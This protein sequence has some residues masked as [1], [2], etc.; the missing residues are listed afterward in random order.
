DALP[1]CG[2]RIEPGE[3]EAQLLA[4]PAV[5]DAAV[6]AC[7]APGGTALVAWVSLQGDSDATR[8]RAALGETL[9][10]YMVPA[11]IT[12]LAAL[13]LNA[14]GKVD[15]QALPAPVFGSEQPYAAPQGD[16]EQMLARLWQQVLSVEHV[17]RADNFFDLGGDSILSLQI[18]ARCQQAGWQITPRQMFEHQTIA[19][20]ATVAEPVQATHMEEKRAT[21]RDL[22]PDE[23]CDRLALNEAQIEDVYPLSPTQEGMLFHSM[24]EPGMYINQLSIAVQGLDSDR[25]AQAWRTM[26][27]R[28]PILRSGVLWQPGM[29]RPLQSVWRDVEAEIHHLDWR[30]E[31]G[32]TARLEA[33][34]TQ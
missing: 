30:G 6:M 14:N 33:F 15:R 8:L 12:V 26:L 24:E 7:D 5:R 16:I 28:H 10:D 2:F 34:L 19:A 29:Q 21:L 4:Q 17:G 32:M 25:L 31:A 13:P 27:A 18:V 20:L 22:L 3:V 23:L 11:V 1:I 9:P